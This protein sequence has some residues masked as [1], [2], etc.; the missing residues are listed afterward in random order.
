MQKI[1]DEEDEILMPIRQTAG[2]MGAP[3]NINFLAKMGAHFKLYF[4]RKLI[5][6][7]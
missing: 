5:A 4:R 1:D 3:G 6:F 7:Q 2:E